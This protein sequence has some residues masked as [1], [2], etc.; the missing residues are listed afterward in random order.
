MVI[1]RIDKDRRLVIHQEGGFDQERRVTGMGW[2][3]ANTE[4]WG[5][6]YQRVN[7][8]REASRY[9]FLPL[10]ASRERLGGVLAV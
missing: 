6:D 2:V 1:L 8:V 4:E 7:V 10:S 3:V 5:V 9:I